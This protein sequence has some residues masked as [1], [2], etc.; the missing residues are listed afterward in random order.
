MARPY[1]KYP[2][3]WEFGTLEPNKA[4]G[5][6]DKVETGG[7]PLTSND[8]FWNG[9]IPWLTPKDIVNSEEIYISKTE[10]YI[11]EEGSKKS[12][13]KI[14]PPGTVM[15]TKRA[16]VG[17]VTINSIPMCTNQGFLNFCCGPK[18]KPLY[19]YYWF[20]IN[21]PYLDAVAN[22]STYP[23]L[24]KG[25]LFELEIAIPPLEEQ[26]KIIELISTLQF[27]KLSG[28]ALAESTSDITQ[29]S[30]IQI[31]NDELKES[32]EQ[33][34]FFVFSGQITVEEIIKGEV[35]AR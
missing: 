12:S 29:L 9:E 21:K 25:D 2:S 22:G 16:P 31:E 17:A 18:L 35:N 20:K 3:N 4:K 8:D 23:E 1:L 6:I 24:Y 11:S 33:L 34:I 7:T 27:A 13:A 10:R 15:L 28:K 14:L 30:I 32:I 19:L 5:F 26:E